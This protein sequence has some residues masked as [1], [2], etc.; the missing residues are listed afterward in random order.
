MRRSIFLFGSIL[1]TVSVL[2]GTWL[3]LRNDSRTF[4]AEG[5][6]AGF[7]D[8]G[9]SVFVEHE[10]ISGYMPAMTMPFAVA[11][12]A[13]LSGLDLGDAVRFTLETG[14]GEALITEMTRIPDT[15]VAR[16]PAGTPEGADTVASAGGVLE[17]GDRLPAATLVDQD[18]DSLALAD[19]R[20][21][22]LAVTFI[23]T[24]CPVADQ[25]PLMS[26]SFRR[27]QPRFRE[28][29][30]ERAH[31]LSVSFDPEYDRPAV[32]REYADRYTDR[33]DNWSFLTGSPREIRTLTSFF[34]IYTMQGP[35][36][37]VHN[38]TTAVVDPEGRVR[39]IW[40]GN[41]WEP[42]EVFRAVREALRDPA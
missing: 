14:G 16:H 19:L 32:L 40:R 18:G 12:T 35:D 22:A 20:G 1:I 30:G 31:L 27:L 41:Q 29:F 39:R 7:R 36:Q 3:L 28:A 10:R 34:Q 13:L 33:T 23:Y 26:R 38:L 21:K 5:R 9:R 2:G 15:A 37:V 17:V 4:R 25:C 8:G 11:D 42:D 6:I 24:R